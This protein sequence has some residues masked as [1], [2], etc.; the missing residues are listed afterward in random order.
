MAFTPERTLTHERVGA[1]GDEVEAHRGLVGAVT[2]S[3]A[4]LAEN[5][6]SNRLRRRKAAGGFEDGELPVG[7]RFRGESHQI[8]AAAE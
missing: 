8:V 3:G 5:R 1:L 4:R 7:V 6:R 2:R